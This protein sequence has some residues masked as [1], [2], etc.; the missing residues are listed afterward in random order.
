[1]FQSEAIHLQIKELFTLPTAADTVLYTTEEEQ[2]GWVE[3]VFVEHS[4]DN[5]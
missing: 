3:G 1:M 5:L 4:N 2:S